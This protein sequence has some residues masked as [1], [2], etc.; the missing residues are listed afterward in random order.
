MQLE[1][2][3]DVAP[4]AG[5][6]VSWQATLPI[7]SRDWQI[8]L[9]VGPSGC[10]KTTLARQ[11]FGEPLSFDWPKDKCI[12]DAFS[13]SMTIQDIVA[14]LSCVGLSSPPCWLRPYHVL[15]CGEQ[16]RAHT[17][18][19]LASSNDLIVID[20]FTSVVDRLVAQIGSHAIA[21]F[22][23]RG[24][25]KKF[26]AVACHYDIIEWL[27][28]DW[29]YEPA[30]DTF[31]WR[32]LRRSPIELQIERT[33]PQAWR[34]FK[35]HHYLDTTLA[36]SA[37]CFIAYVHNQP[38][39]FCSVL[40]FPHPSK[41]GWREHRTVCLPDFQGVGIGNTLANY[42]ASLYAATGK[43]YRS[44]TSH[45]AM[46]AH[47]KRSPEWKMTIAPSIRSRG[48]TTSLKKLVARASFNRA[49]ASFEYTG[50]ANIQDAA[51][52]GICNWQASNQE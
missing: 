44:T 27:C 29:T 20:E 7:E 26:V 10:G 12:V 14:V 46:I 48:T 24:S 36:K 45:P 51:K 42:V 3:F 52:F 11:L 9:I 1:G 5:S 22:L 8:G 21:K 40:S 15:S 37:A 38:A 28:P 47:R 39:A 18:R 4:G 23:R 41:P 33:T 49:P 43:P 25:N 50:P 2:M 30:T 34:I 32:S 19:L 16:F 13:E 17:A 31:Q 6:S 35:K